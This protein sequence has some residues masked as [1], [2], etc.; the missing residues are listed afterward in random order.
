MFSVKRNNKCTNFLNVYNFLLVKSPLIRPQVNLLQ[1]SHSNEFSNKAASND[2]LNGTSAQSKRPVEKVYQKISQ[3]EH[4]LLRPDTYDGP[5]QTTT[6]KLLVYDSD[7]RM[8]LYKI[9]DKILV[10]AADNK[11]HSPSTDTIKV[12]IRSGVIA[13]CQLLSSNTLR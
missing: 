6:E 8:G 4:N 3:L 9:V 11:I 7:K 13:L 2:S 1:K 12:D 10:N 5:V